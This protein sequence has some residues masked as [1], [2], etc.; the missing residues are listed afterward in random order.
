MNVGS[1]A[2]EERKRRGKGVWDGDYGL[3][4]NY[5]RGGIDVGSDGLRGARGAD[6]MEGRRVTS[7]LVSEL[8]FKVRLQRRTHAD[9]GEE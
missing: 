3:G 9:A 6:G 4:Q 5:V 2:L 7:I 1:D 8:C